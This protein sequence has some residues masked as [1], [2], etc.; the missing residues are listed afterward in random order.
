MHV[1]VERFIDCAAAVHVDADCSRWTLKAT[2]KVSFSLLTVP[3][4]NDIFCECLLGDFSFLH[5]RKFKAKFCQPTG[6]ARSDKAPQNG[7]QRGVS[8]ETV[9]VRPSVC[10][11]VPSGEQLWR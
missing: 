6:G 3:D 7:L 11:S 10:L 4:V 9:S 1:Q 8:N 2:P 5:K